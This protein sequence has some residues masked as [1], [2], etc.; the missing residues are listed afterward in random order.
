MSRKTASFSQ[1]LAYIAGE[2]KVQGDPITH[3]LYTD[4]SNIET[5][6]QAF[7]ANARYCPPR[8][9]G[10]ILYHE[11]LSISGGDRSQV[12]HEI[13]TD[14]AQKY[15]ALRAAEALVF[16]T[17]HFEDNPH[18]HLMISGNLSHRPEKLRLSQSEFNRIKRD[19][20]RYQKENYPQLTH[21]LVFEQ[22]RG[23]DEQKGTS[24]YHKIPRKSSEQ[25]RARRRNRQGIAANSQKD[26]LRDH[27]RLSL[28]G[29]FSV[30]DFS[31]RLRKH[32]IS[33]Y[34]RRNNL[35]G[36]VFQGK[37]YRFRTIGLD[38]SLEEA[39]IRWERIPE[40]KKILSDI[41][42]D[43]TRQRGRGRDVEF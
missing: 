9:N 7:L 16:G 17:I 20:E 31:E 33:L 4:G 21:S 10:V 41:L 15:I 39:M 25:E 14:L 35:S 6:N 22:G 27:V 36:V 38:A 2:G 3:N 23:R 28:V 8:K 32:D 24:V 18:V 1:L 5:V 19:L 43:K 42:V 30:S 37:K 11:I 34:S 12:T 29:A 40:R 26:C 13:L